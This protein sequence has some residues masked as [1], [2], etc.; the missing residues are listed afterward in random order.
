MYASTIQYGCDN[1]KHSAPA[2]HRNRV[3]KKKEKRGEEIKGFLAFAYR[4]NEA[5]C[6][7]MERTNKAN[8]TRSQSGVANTSLSLSL[9]YMY[10]KNPGLFMQL[11]CRCVMTFV[12]RCNSC[13]RWGTRP[14]FRS[15]G[16]PFAETRD[17]KLEF[18]P[19]CV[20]RLPA[21]TVNLSVDSKQYTL[22]RYKVRKK[23]K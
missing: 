4:R 17:Y 7:F 3:E 9:R 16:R 2:A 8:R 14:S 18:V 15:R 19:P 5:V 6:I 10:S 11:F 20:K 23:L 22:Q 12:C 21:T 1:N 13:R